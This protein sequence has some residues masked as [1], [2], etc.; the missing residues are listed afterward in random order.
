VMP[1]TEMLRMLLDTGATRIRF[2][3]IGSKG[4]IDELTTS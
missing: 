3:G 4:K 1:V 2:T